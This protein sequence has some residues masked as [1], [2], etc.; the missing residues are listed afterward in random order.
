[1]KFGLS[2]EDFSLFQ[3]LVIDP[4]KAEGCRLYVFGSRA[5]QKHQKFSDIDVLIDMPNASSLSRFYQIKEAIEEARF[6]IKV[7]FVLL[8]NL[9]ESYAQ[10][11]HQE[12][13]EL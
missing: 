1:M 12:K 7:D 5:T 3:K 11:I 4:L 6:P 10:K 2:P 13:I 9:A 8:G